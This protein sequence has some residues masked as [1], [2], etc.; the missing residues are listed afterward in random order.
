MRYLIVGAGKSGLAAAQL[1][2]VRN[3]EFDL[4]DEKLK[5]LPDHLQDLRLI[6]EVKIANY[7]ALVASPGLPFHHHV[8]DKAR[9]FRVPIISEVD[10]ALSGYSGKILA[11]TGTNGKS[12]TSA[13]CFHLL[14][15]SGFRAQLAGNIGIPI[16]DLCREGLH[17]YIVL[18]V[19]SYQAE[20][21]LLIC[22]QVCIFT[23]FS[24]DHL[25][26]H[27]TLGE[28]FRAK[29][30]LV[31][32]MNPQ[33]F[34][35]TE[36]HVS[37]F[38]EKEGFSTPHHT[39]MS[40]QIPEALCASLKRIEAICEPHN[41]K[42]AYQA[43]LAV[44]CLTQIDISELWPKLATFQG[45]EH[46]CER[47]GSLGA[48]LVIN[49]SKSTNI[50]S[51]LTALKAFN[52]KIALLLG[53]RPKK[54]S[55][56]PLLDYSEKISRVIT[57]G[58]ASAQVKRELKAL[59]IQEIPHISQLPELLMSHPLSEDV[60][61]FSPGCASFDQFQNFEDRGRQFKIVISKLT[62]L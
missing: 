36:Q 16:T 14:K 41:L 25:E 39:F 8:L 34:F 60:L 55:M 43:L 30:S 53:G 21:S 18:E 4:F 52:G 33:S 3:I 46:R 58:E 26:R 62:N 47:V 11:V 19:S 56:L 59:K 61:L 48:T 45:L 13:M 50:D 15:E 10:L 49:D 57:F 1:L 35:V 24:P 7:S 40:D 27:G 42:N 32:Q 5:A 31:K 51:T 20:M 23:N 6:S 29:M 9:E 37:E 17:E 54:E 44:S 2:K 12:T 28:Y 38:I 22:P